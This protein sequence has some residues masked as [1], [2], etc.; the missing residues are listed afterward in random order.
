MGQIPLLLCSPSPP[1][2]RGT[3]ARAAC[4]AVD[5]SARPI[6]QFYYEKDFCVRDG[7]LPPLRFF[8]HFCFLREKACGGQQR[9]LAVHVPD[10]GIYL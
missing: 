2:L 4:A 7:A 1:G 9:A 8:H 5:E 3:A 10:N 6:L